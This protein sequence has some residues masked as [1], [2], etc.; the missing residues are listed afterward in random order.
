MWQCPEVADCCR[1]L[2]VFLFVRLS[3][4]Y[5]YSCPVIRDGCRICLR[6]DSF[7]PSDTAL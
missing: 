7:H 3:R 4:L 1:T 5:E 2:A 6:P